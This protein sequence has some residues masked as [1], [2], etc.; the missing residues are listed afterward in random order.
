MKIYFVG[1]NSAGVI[2]KFYNIFVF[3]VTTFVLKEVK[4]F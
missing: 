4:A 2:L 1:V 3:I